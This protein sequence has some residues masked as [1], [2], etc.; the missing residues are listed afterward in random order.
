MKAKVK[1]GNLLIELK[2]QNPRP[3]STGKTLL[4]ASTNGVRRSTAL[5]DGREISV[6]ANAFIFP[7]DTA[8]ANLKHTS[9]AKK[10]SHEEKDDMDEE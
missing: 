1:N 5:V 2:L 6:V 8:V 10:K 3:S 7:D 9:T 4:V